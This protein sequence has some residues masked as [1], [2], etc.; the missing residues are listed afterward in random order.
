MRIYKYYIYMFYIILSIC[1]M[2]IYMYINHLMTCTLSTRL[3]S[4]VS[5]CSHRDPK[6]L[7][8]DPPRPRS[9]MVYRAKACATA[10]GYQ[11]A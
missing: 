9:G 10:R 8:G 1:I 4:V 11:I 3:T 6:N 7:K 5:T 2:Y